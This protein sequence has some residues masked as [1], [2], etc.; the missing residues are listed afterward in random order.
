MYE[1]RRTMV[2]N[3]RCWDCMHLEGRKTTFEDEPLFY[4]CRLG[5][6]CGNPLLRRCDMYRPGPR[7]VYWPWVYCRRCARCTEPVRVLGGRCCEC[8]L[9]VAKGNVYGRYSRCRLFEARSKKHR[10]NKE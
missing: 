4:E 9:G 6:R 7:Q 5:G 8:R 2:P 3:R 1:F 10:D